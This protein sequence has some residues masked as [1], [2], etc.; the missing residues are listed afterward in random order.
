MTP[1]LI[2]LSFILNSCDVSS[3]SDSIKSLKDFLGDY[4]YNGSTSH[5]LSFRVNYFLEIGV[6]SESG[7]C[8]S[9]RS[10][11][12]NEISAS[13]VI[14]SG[15]GTFGTG[16]LRFGL[17]DRCSFDSPGVLFIFYCC[18]SIGIGGFW[19]GWL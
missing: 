6:R 8:K 3:C 7:I 4:Y 18:L 9:D 14:G 10:I 19:I 1:L 12:V 2:I 11:I 15:R 16:R 5:S 17:L 13:F